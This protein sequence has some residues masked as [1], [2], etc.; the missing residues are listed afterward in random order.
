MCLGP[1]IYCVMH[2]CV[3]V[4]DKERKEEGEKD[5]YGSQFCI[6]Y[7][8]TYSTTSNPRIKSKRTKFLKHCLE[9]NLKY[10]W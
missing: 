8:N 7:I 3:G 6:N 5:I 9:I 4:W 2:L 1:H 10:E